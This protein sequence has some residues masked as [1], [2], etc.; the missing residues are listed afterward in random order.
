GASDCRR[1]CAAHLV[2]L[3]AGWSPGAF[4]ERLATAGG[5]VNLWRV[6]FFPEQANSQSTAAAPVEVFKME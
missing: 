3:P 5:R 2:R 6:S 1:G 4:E